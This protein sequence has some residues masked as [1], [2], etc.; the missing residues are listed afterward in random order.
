MKIAVAALG[1]KKSSEI[2][3]Q[4]G[5]AP[6]YLIFDENETLLETLKNPFSRGGGGA[7]FGVAKMLADRKVSVAVAGDF[8][9]KM[10][11]A[12]E[13]RGLRAYKSKGTVLEA[14]STLEEQ[15][16]P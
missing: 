13:Q 5:R 4:A 1:K 3:E 16:Q 10:T 15:G 6:F 12:L 9:Q 8:G 7:G 2:A 11:A 14:L